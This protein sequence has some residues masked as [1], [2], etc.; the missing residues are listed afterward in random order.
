MD[1]LFHKMRKRTQSLAREREREREREIAH[2]QIP[3]SI[4]HVMNL[5]K[6]Q[7]VGELRIELLGLGLEFKSE[8]RK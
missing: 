2:T 7:Q 8:T 5:M 6:Q 3:N 4:S 1:L